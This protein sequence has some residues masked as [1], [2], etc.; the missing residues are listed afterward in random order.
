MNVSLQ[1]GI[2]YPPA[3]RKSLISARIQGGV[4]DGDRLYYRGPGCCAGGVYYVWKP[5]TGHGGTAKEGG[6]VVIT[7]C[8]DSERGAGRLRNGREKHRPA[9]IA[10][11]RST[12]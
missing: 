3:L 9:S 4:G 8:E 5:G 7:Q 10:R 11:M 6:S 2:E 1:L 12:P